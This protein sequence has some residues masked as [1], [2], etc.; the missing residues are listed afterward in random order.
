MDIWIDGK[1]S[2]AREKLMSNLDFK[3][4]SL[5]DLQQTYLTAHQTLQSRTIRP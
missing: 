4:I 5:L 1:Q 2:F 3:I